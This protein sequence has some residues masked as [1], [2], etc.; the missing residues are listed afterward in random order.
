MCTGILADQDVAHVF[1]VS[2]VD[3][4][5]HICASYLIDYLLD[6]KSKKSSTMFTPATCW[7]AAALG[8]FLTLEHSRPP[9]LIL[10]FSKTTTMLFKMLS[11]ENSWQQ[12]QDL[13]PSRPR[14][15]FVTQSRVL[16]DKVEEYFM[17]LLE[18]INLASNKSM[19][20]S[21]LMER[22]QNRDEALLV[23]R[24][25][26]TNWR[27]DLP[28]KFSELQDDHFPIFIT[29]DKVGIMQ[30]RVVTYSTLTANA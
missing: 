11:Y 7:V 3:R 4:S 6:R 29:F 9:Y 10:P 17:K 1:H 20:I 18:S 28:K 19:D 2:Y 22:K 12:A 14:Q 8:I 5:K 25:E 16:A 15:L 26:A 23:D 30:S 24:D 27:N 13:I 21:A